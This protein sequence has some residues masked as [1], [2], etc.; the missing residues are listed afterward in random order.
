MLFNFKKQKKEIFIS[1]SIDDLAGLKDVTVNPRSYSPERLNDACNNICFDAKFD[2][3]PIENLTIQFIFR[4]FFYI[5]HQTGLYNPQKK[6]FYHLASTQKIEIKQYTKLPKHL[7][8][9]GKISDMFFYDMNGRFLQVRL[10]HPGLNYDFVPLT[11]LFN[12]VNYAKAN[13]VM[14]ISNRDINE[15]VIKMVRAKTNYTNPLERFSAPLNNLVS[16][17]LL[18]YQALEN[19]LNYKL[20]YPDLEKQDSVQ[21]NISAEMIEYFENAGI[22]V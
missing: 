5:M 16:F 14:Y 2:I 15:Q 12:E 7:K 21:A 22:N 18:T 19:A 13:G 4:K 10:E 3:D 17:N 1:K 20:V 6:F 8:E 9:Q 11:K